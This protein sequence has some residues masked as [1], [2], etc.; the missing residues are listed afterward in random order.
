MDMGEELGLET[1]A[2]CA[3]ES[4]SGSSMETPD[5]DEL[6]R[7]EQPDE[8]DKKMWEKQPWAKTRTPLWTTVWDWNN[9]D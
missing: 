2:G 7:P 6:L 1:G 9:P 5:L 8:R 3:Q 4:L